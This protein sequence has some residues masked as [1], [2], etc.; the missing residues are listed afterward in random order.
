MKVEV[1]ESIIYSWLRHIK[2]CQV[3]QLNW[4]TS[5]SWKLKGDIEVV[6]DIME[7]ANKKF[8]NPFKG[9]KTISQLIRQAEVDGLGMDA[10][11]KRCH[12]VDV[13]FHEDGLNYGSKQKTVNNVTKKILRA[14]FVLHL[15]FGEPYMFFI[16]F[17]SPK[18]T[19]SAYG[20]LENR[21]EEIR[22]FLSDV[23][24]AASVQLIANE[25]FGA[26]VL[27]PVLHVAQSHSDTS[28]L[29]MRSIQL[30]KMFEV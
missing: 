4:K 11:K 24:I 7:K 16:Y 27:A 5:P 26:E 6:Q 17:V 10:L 21:I 2:Q 22:G 18:I 9:T 8:D 28:E 12:A 29:F 14:A 19:P 30:A 15:Y 25:N 13:A 23:N 1:G 20:A 3:V